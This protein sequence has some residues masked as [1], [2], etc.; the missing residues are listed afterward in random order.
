MDDVTLELEVIQAVG[1]AL[2]KLPD[3]EAQRRVVRWINDRFQPSAVAASSDRS[4]HPGPGSAIA[5]PFLAVGELEDLFE[6][7]GAKP[8]TMHRE[9]AARPIAA[10]QIAKAPEP[11]PGID[12]LV[13][14]FVSDFQRVALEWQG[15]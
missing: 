13:R 7:P 12:S 1:R 15:A 14:G 8:P 11:E 6:V 10:A 3:G 2:A 4:D 9:A 5:D